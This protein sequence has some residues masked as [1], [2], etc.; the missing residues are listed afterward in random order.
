MIIFL[1]AVVAM[2]IADVFDAMQTVCEARGSAVVA[3][4][5]CAV[6]NALTLGVGAVGADTLITHGVGQA[7]VLGLLVLITTFVST[8]LATAWAAKHV[9][10]D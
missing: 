3:G 7:L 4:A 9:K 6:N 2:A 5:L 8:A 10:V 1:I